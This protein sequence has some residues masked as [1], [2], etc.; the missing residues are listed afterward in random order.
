MLEVNN[1]SL[2]FDTV[3]VLHQ[4]SFRLKK[5][6]TYGILGE[7]GVGKSSLLNI[8]SGHLYPSEGQIWCHGKLMPSHQQMLLPGHP[9]IALVSSS[10]NLDWNH[11]CQENIRESILGMENV[12]REKKV[13]SYL[14]QLK[15]HKA[16]NIKAKLLSEGEKQ[17]LA[18]ARSLAVTPSWLLLD[19]PFSHQDLSNKIAIMNLILNACKSNNIGLLLVSHNAQEIMM[20]CQKIA[21]LNT[22]GKL[23]RFN[24]TLKSYFD[25][26]NKGLAELMGPVNVVKWKGLTYTF[27]PSS[28]AICQDG[29]P[30]DLQNAYFNGMVHVHLFVTQKGE[31]VILYNE[32]YLKHQI[33]IQPSTNE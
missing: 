30:L 11:T 12:A 32:N 22:K 24:S 20:F 18:I 16:R 21:F 25:L 8:I 15:L 10:F 17:R 19:E 31:E 14:R 7:S 9:E 13:E 26:K 27:R 33:M 2:V 4:V 6:I 3:R 1:L 29:I 5:G 28:F 23:T